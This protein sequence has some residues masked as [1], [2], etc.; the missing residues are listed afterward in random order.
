MV[1][2]VRVFLFVNK[3][4]KVPCLQHV[5]TRNSFTKLTEI[6]CVLSLQSCLKRLNSF[7]AK[8]TALWQSKYLYSTEHIGDFCSLISESSVNKHAIAPSHKQEVG[9]GRDG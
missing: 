2:S 9:G 8:I 7:M 4:E 5:I 3:H 1:D 6:S